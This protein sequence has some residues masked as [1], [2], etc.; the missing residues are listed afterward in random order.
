MTTKTDVAPESKQGIF[1]RLIDRVLSL[2]RLARIV[3]IAVFSLSVALL[4]SP[5]VD[6]VY[7]TAMFTYETRILPAIVTAAAGFGMYIAGW[8]LIVGYA[9]EK[10]RS[11][12]AVLIYCLAGVSAFLGVIGLLISGLVNLALS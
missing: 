10:S 4:L 7:L 8:Y 2:P 5:L 1:S 11:R 3:L 12:I 6:Y 9:G